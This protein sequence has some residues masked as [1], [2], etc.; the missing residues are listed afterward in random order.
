M[1]TKT[2]KPEFEAAVKLVS[3]LL[4]LAE[5]NGGRVFFG[6]SKGNRWYLV[7]ETL[8]NHHGSDSVC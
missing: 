2:K 5:K 3:D 8:N 6:D 4:S 1:K 7:K